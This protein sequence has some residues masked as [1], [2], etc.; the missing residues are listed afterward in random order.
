MKSLLNNPISI[1]D[2]SGFTIIELMISTLVFGLILMVAISGINSYSVNYYKA[3]LNSSV[4]STVQS[5]SSTVED[6]IKPSGLI[7]FGSNYYCTENQEFIFALGKE[8]PHE[9]PVSMPYALYQ[10]PDGGSC[11]PD[12]QSSPA[13]QAALA[14]GSSLLGNN[15]RLLNFSINQIGTTNE[16]SIDIKLAYTNGGLNDAGDDLLCK[17][18]TAYNMVGGC[19][20]ASP[21][22]IDFSSPQSFICKPDV[23]RQFCDVAELQSIVSERLY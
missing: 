8:M 10:F 12:P 9:V 18:G 17:P 7:S 4:Q 19:G 5:I 15:Y 23:G 21:Q 22:L 13:G 1:S 6:A 16:W 11:Y 3:S 2:Q 20:P 14:A